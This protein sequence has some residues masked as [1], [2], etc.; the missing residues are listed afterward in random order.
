MM[1]TR[2]CG[3][4]DLNMF[5]T[6]TA[7]SLNSLKLQCPIPNGL[8]HFPFV[9]ISHLE[10]K[11]DVVDIETLFQDF[12]NLTSLSTEDGYIVEQSA[13]I[14]DSTSPKTCRTMETLTLRHGGN[15]KRYLSICRRS[16]L[17][18][19]TFTSL[20]VIHLVPSNEGESFSKRKAPGWCHLDHS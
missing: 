15:L 4:R 12:P 17:P 20:R 3:A 19:F 16:T 8:A 1:A 9:Q 13:Q 11:T 7:P 6:D 10:F 2:V 14:L 18:F 5:T